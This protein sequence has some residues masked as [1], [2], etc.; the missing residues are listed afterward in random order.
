MSYSD[1]L[2]A[3]TT[4]RGKPFSLQDY[5]FQRAIIDDTH[6]NMDVIKCS[7]VGL[8]EVQMRKALAFLVRN[9]GLSAIFT[10]PNE[11]M[12]KRVSQTRFK[13]LVD[14]DKVFNKERDQG[15]VRSMS[16]MQFGDSFLYVTGCSE[17]DATSIPADAVFNDEVDL[18]PQD[19]LALFSSRLQGSDWAINQRF[20]TPTF[21]SFG[22]DLGFRSSDQHHY[23][24]KC[25]KCRKWNDPEF[26]RSHIY[27][28]GLPDWVESLTDI[29]EE[30]IDEI[31]VVGSYVMCSHCSA[32]L[33]LSD[34][35]VREWVPKH[36]NRQHARGYKVT[37]FCTHRLTPEY[38]ITQLLKYKR[39]DYLRG[40]YN[41]V[42]GE[43]YSD[44]NIQLSRDAVEQCFTGQPA[45]PTNIH[46]RD[47]VSVGIDMGQTCHITVGVGSS[48]E[49]MHVIRFMAVHV[50]DL[51]DKVEELCRI[52]NVV[53]G[54]VDRHP[55]EPKADDVFTVS[56]G[57]IVPTEYR[58]TKEVNLVSNPTGDDVSHAQA[59]RTRM[60]DQVVRYVKREPGLRFSGY[61]HYRETIIAHLRDMIRDEQPDQPAQWQKLTGN[62]HFFH[63]LGFML[64]GL[65]IKEV[66][67]AK[68]NQEIRTQSLTSVVDMDDKAG[69][70]FGRGNKSLEVGVLG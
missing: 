46:P 49:N 39:R 23:L 12:Y 33:I 18:S 28:P 25:P 14:N 52:Y 38:I 58:G 11:K 4:L 59:D 17:G 45:V 68:D 47:P 30:I 56:R 70:I 16:L 42:L 31:D 20:G 51:I 15:S 3:N 1:W 37:P 40:F 27:I 21:P 24:V 10:L 44:G 54:A 55:Y 43:T 9:R 29:E 69:N 53:A 64:I 22:V 62:D 48:P 63:S 34:P 2:V 5:W 57:K 26:S 8:T 36:P 41:T 13:P 32:A 67:R 60:L 61:G 19:M 66:E 7:Q 6:T 65:K 50:D 35:E